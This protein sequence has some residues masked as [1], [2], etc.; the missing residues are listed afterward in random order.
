MSVRHSTTTKEDA[1]I[2]FDNALSLYFGDCDDISPINDDTTCANIVKEGGQVCNF[3]P[4]HYC[5][6]SC[7]KCSNGGKMLFEFDHTDT[8]ES[9]NIKP[10]EMKEVFSQRMVSRSEM[11]ALTGEHNKRIVEKKKKKED[12][13]ADDTNKDKKAERIPHGHICALK[14]RTKVWYCC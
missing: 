3:E 1:M 12:L 14:A 9:S 5:K 11:V 7:F 8:D 10:E 2:D 13:R 6:I 4:Q